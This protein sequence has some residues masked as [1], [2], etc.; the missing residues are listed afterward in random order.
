M[1][2]KLLIAENA[3]TTKEGSQIQILIL[4]LK[5]SEKR[6][7]LT[8]SKQREGDKNQDRNKQS[9]ELKNNTENKWNQKLILWK[10][11]QNWQTFS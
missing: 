7:N 9:R 4:Y 8:Q 5:I 1:L 6:P 3:C 11:Q 2:G 10:G